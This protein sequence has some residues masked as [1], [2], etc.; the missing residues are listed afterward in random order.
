MQRSFQSNRFGNLIF[1]SGAA[2]VAL[3]LAAC[4][5]QGGPAQRGI[6]PNGAADGPTPTPL[7]TR[8][9]APRTSVAADGVLALT[10][11]SVVLGFESTGRIKAI[12]VVP[13]QKVKVGEV[14]AELDDIQL[15]EALA[16][17]KDQLAVTDA[18]IKNNSVPAKK[19]DIDN[20][21][22]S[23]SS[24]YA[25]YNEQKQVPA[26]TDI[27]QAMRSWNQAKNSLWQSQV[28]R[29]QMCFFD[30]D[31]N[32][33]SNNDKCKTAS[34]N[35]IAAE[36]NERA[37]YS[38]YIAAQAPT[39]ADK[40]ASA[41]SDVVSAQGNLAKLQNNLT[42]EQQKVYELQLRQAKM[43]VDRAESDLAKAKLL[44]PCD[45]VVQ[46]VTMVVGGVAS[47]NGI[48]LLDTSSLRFRTTNLSELDV[49]RI[50]AGQPVSIRLKSFEQSFGG[51]V[52]VVLPISSGTQGSTAQYTVLVAIEPNEAALL[53]GMTGQA[54]IQ[55]AV[56]R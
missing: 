5:P 43:S 25:R 31:K 41:W 21:R 26:A 55:V 23:L 6:G 27:E 45:C 14:L 35:V 53:P 32:I 8:V 29:D 9:I 18:Q 15:Q 30:P 50:K 48:T 20:A 17:A 7:P 42:P 40:L 49:V 56:A 51:R 22:A 38:R 46:D 37:A 34:Y 28:S 47:S 3:A 13:G 19:T 39:T 54:E 44:S 4:G 10:Q 1:V 36:Q 24:A 52:Q 2:A 16:Q 11:P 33:Y 12:N